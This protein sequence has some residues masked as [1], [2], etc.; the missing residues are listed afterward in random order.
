MPPPAADGQTVCVTQFPRQAADT[1]S[2]RY[3]RKRRA[4]PGAEAT[5]S[6]TTSACLKL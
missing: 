2:S 6:T 3:R 4:A 1:E 5:P